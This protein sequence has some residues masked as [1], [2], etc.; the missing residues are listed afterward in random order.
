M[1]M[2]ITQI[3]DEEMSSGDVASMLKEALKMK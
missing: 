2:F 1:M 3:L